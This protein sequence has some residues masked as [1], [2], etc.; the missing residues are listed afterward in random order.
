MSDPA[1][2]KFQFRKNSTFSVEESTFI[3]FQY[4]KLKHTAAV[5]RAFATK[6]YP[7]HPRKV[8]SQN[9]FQRVIQ[10]FLASASVRPS[11][12]AG[13]TLM[14]EE[15]VQRVRELFEKNPKAHIREAVNEPSWNEPTWSE[16]SL[17]PGCP[18]FSGIQVWGQDHFQEIA[19]PLATLQPG[20][21][22]S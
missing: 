10:R 9:V 17:H 16:P 1:N 13:P 18:V 3:I 7:K 4:G 2:R 5:R 14:S 12:S 15:K 20:P 6:F 19:T 21:Q 8:P 22:P 11:I